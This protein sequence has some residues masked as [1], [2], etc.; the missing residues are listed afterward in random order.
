MLDYNWNTYLLVLPF[1][2]LCFYIGL[3]II[4]LITIPLGLAYRLY[5]AVAKTKLLASSKNNH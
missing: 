5:F 4:G 1:V 3:F 2:F